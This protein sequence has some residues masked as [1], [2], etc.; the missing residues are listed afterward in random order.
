MSLVGV[1]LGD[2]GRR[3]PLSQGDGVVVGAHSEGVN[4]RAVDPDYSNYD[5]LA[6]LGQ[7][8][9]RTHPRTNRSTISGGIG[10]N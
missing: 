3:L 6:D 4:A 2:R 10:P 1:F 9:R 8:P 5:I 7:A